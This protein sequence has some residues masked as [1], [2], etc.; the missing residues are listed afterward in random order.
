MDGPAF[1]RPQRTGWLR[2]VRS[3]IWWPFTCG[4]STASDASLELSD[5]RAQLQRWMGQQSVDIAG[6]PFKGLQVMGLL[7]SRGLDFDE[8]FILDVNEGILPDGSPPPTFMPL[9]LQRAN[10]FRGGLSGTASSQRT[11]TACSTGPGRFTSSTSGPTWA[12]GATEPSRHI[13]QLTRWAQESLPGVDVKR[14]R[15]STPL[16][17]CGAARA[18]PP[19]VRHQSS[20]PDHLLLNGISPSAL[21]QAIRCNR[22]FHYR[23]VLG[24]GEADTVEEHLEASTIGTVIH[25]AVELGS[26]GPLAGTSSGATSSAWPRRS[27]RG[28]RNIGPHQ[29]WGQS[30]RWRKCPRAPHGRRHDW[31]LGAG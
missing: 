13:A 1:R 28:W 25:K 14:Q 31:A 29:T 8:V 3:E 19:M 17:G 27:N 2:L 16:A 26:R 7:E 24:L 10:D 30:A 4:V 21:N 5:A 23:Y 11:C 6:E 15:W 22:Q 18:R 9:D 12:M 20:G